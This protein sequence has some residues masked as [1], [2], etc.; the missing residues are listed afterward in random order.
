MPVQPRPWRGGIGRLI[1]LQVEIFNREDPGSAF[2]S[3]VLILEEEE[4][5]F[6]EDPWGHGLIPENQG[7]LEKF[8]Q[9]AEEHVYIPNRPTLSDLF[10]LV[11]R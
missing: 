3:A 4:G 7:V 1:C 6:G 8:V 5:I 2:P 10:V 11:G 9:Y